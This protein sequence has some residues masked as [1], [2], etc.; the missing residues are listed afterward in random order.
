MSR[1]ID[2]FFKSKVS[3][4]VEPFKRDDWLAFNSLLDNEK[5]QPKY[6]FLFWSVLLFLILSFLFFIPGTNPF[7]SADTAKNIDKIGDFATQ[8]SL[9]TVQLS[10]SG[11]LGLR[12]SAQSSPFSN[13][14]TRNV[15]FAQQIIVRY[16]RKGSYGSKADEN[17]KYNGRTGAGSFRLFNLIPDFENVLQSE[18]M[19]KNTDF[20][21][22]VKLDHL[23]ALSSL[24]KIGHSKPLSID[25]IPAVYYEL[26][27]QFSYAIGMLLG[28]YSMT[29]VGLSFSASYPLN[30][31]INM[32]VRPGMIY[33]TSDQMKERY[34]HQHYDFGL[35]ETEIELERN[36]SIQLEVPIFAT[37]RN[38][39]HQFGIGGGMQWALWDRFEKTEVNNSDK[40]RVAEEV[41]ETEILSDKGWRSS[42]LGNSSFV[43]GFYQYQISPSFQ[44][45]LRSRWLLSSQKAEAL[46]ESESLRYGLIL[47]Y[48]LK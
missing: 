23:S 32:M 18:F 38:G 4:H 10:N 19:G 8:E 1:K 34:Y 14:G 28:N 48:T 42:R 36:G 46:E 3:E 13:L 47:T 40:D 25:K 2:Q 43:E 29:D 16:E 27:S 26:P 11:I 39:R 20:P 21:E 44:L 35:N 33:S 22:S 17:T 24:N 12:S 45:G 41:S 15:P 9:E 5:T 31:N 6:G 7:G 37:F 30:D